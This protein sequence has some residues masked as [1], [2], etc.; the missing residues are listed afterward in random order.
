MGRPDQIQHRV[1]FQAEEIVLQAGLDGAQSQS[2][3]GKELKRK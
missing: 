3:G 1:P 2:G